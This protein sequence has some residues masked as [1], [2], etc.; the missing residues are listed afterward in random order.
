MRLEQRDKKKEER[1]KKRKN[2]WRQKT[3]YCKFII[4]GEIVHEVI[5]KMHNWNG[6]ERASWSV[7]GKVE[8][9]MAMARTFGNESQK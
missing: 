8:S 4:H 1:N 5:K 2:K 3:R 6:W 7:A 9:D